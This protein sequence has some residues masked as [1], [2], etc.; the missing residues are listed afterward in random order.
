MTGG[1]T[2][3]TFLVALG[4]GALKSSASS[5]AIGTQCRHTVVCQRGGYS[6]ASQCHG[7]DILARAKHALPAAPSR[8]VCH[9]VHSCGELAYQVFFF[10]RI[11]FTKTCWV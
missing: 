2:E 3:V 8:A 9:G 6:V 7:G 10:L 5:A 1:P 11:Y 4:H